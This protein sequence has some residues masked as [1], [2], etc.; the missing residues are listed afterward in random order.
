[1]FNTAAKACALVTLAFALTHARF[2][3]RLLRRDASARDR[4]L[5]LVV[6]LG[7]A[8]TE[9]AVAQQ[10]TPM[11]ARVIAACVAGLLAGPWVGAAV[12]VGSTL[13]ALGFQPHPPAGF[14]LATVLGGLAGGL[15]AARRPRL[16]LAPLTGLLVGIP[17]SLLRYP[18][19]A[20][21]ATAFG[22]KPPPLS[23]GLEVVT[24][25]VN[26]AGVGLVLL[27]VR[28]VLAREAAARAAADA[29]V[30]SLQARMNPHF[31]FNALNAIAALSAVDPPAVPVA[32][33]R[34]A[35][36]LRGSF[37]GHDRPTVPLGLEL[38]IVSAYLGVEAL[39]FGDRLRVR[40][41]VA[42]DVMT[43][44]VPPFL[45]QPLVEN[46]VQ[47]GIQPRPEGGTVLVLAEA[48][49]GQLVLAV[50]DTGAG[51][52]PER[53][54]VAR[55]DNPAAP[56]ALAL[57]RR[58]LRALYDDRFSFEIASRPGRGTRVTVRLP[59]ARAPGPAAPSRRTRGRAAGEAVG[60]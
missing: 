52:T 32:I 2:F 55:D 22:M 51:M 53:L 57:L 16:A 11:N 21:F 23:L 13:M 8:L 41:R 27:V 24:A 9:E 15:V 26:G 3:V 10:H 37:D 40:R 29:E 31:L 45:I 12:G 42:D 28:Q 18:L 54:A 7:L 25:L 1:M 50:E 39:R 59:L 56:H 48:L 14:G 46:A 20:A 30:R 44:G 6:F 43:A 4:A 49:D 36:F 58:R 60:A 19:T 38:G 5:A 35:R 17:A 33:G 47:H 34:L